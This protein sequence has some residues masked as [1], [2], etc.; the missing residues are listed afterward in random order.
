MM[1]S[2]NTVSKE[3]QVSGNNRLIWGY[4]TMLFNCIYY[5]VSNEWKVVDGGVRGLC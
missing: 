4:L 3:K 2:K 1:L 5:I